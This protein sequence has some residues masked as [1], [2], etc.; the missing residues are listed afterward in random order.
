M[1]VVV[2]VGGVG[3][4]VGVGV[5]GA[6]VVGVLVVIFSAEA[7]NPPDAGVGT[8]GAPDPLEIDVGGGRTTRWSGAAVAAAAAGAAVTTGAVGVATEGVAGAALT[9]FVPSRD[10][11]DGSGQ[12]FS[13]PHTLATAS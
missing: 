8:T 7:R 12:V 3:V 2:V 6:A 5:G 4:V 10:A 11:L 13:G 9:A 1:V